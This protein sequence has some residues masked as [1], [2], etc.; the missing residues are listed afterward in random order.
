MLKNRYFTI[1]LG[2]KEKTTY[3][4]RVK[5]DFYVE[6]IVTNGTELLQG[7]FY[8]YKNIQLNIL[9]NKD[10]TSTICE[11]KGIIGKINEGVSLTGLDEDFISY[12]RGEKIPISIEEIDENSELI[13]KLDYLLRNAIKNLSPNN[14]SIYDYFASKRLSFFKELKSEANSPIHSID[15]RTYVAVDDPKSGITREDLKEIEAYLLSLATNKQSPKGKDETGKKLRKR[16][17]KK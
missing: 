2:N 13:R 17:S 15:G 4:L 7:Y 10:T 9:D 14:K 16:K 5:K 3:F 12:G 11:H 6:G 8:L 1:E